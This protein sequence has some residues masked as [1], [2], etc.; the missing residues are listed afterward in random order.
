[1]LRPL[2]PGDIRRVGATQRVQRWKL[3]N[4]NYLNTERAGEINICTN[5]TA[6]AAM[7]RLKMRERERSLSVWCVCEPPGGVCVVHPGSSSSIFN[8]SPA[9]QHTKAALF[10]KAFQTALV[11]D[12]GPSSSFP[13]KSCLTRC[14]FRGNYWNMLPRRFSLSLSFQKSQMHSR[15][16]G[17]ALFFA[18]G[19]TAFRPA[20]NFAVVLI[21]P[22]LKSSPTFR[23]SKADAPGNRWA[24]LLTFTVWS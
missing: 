17:S 12:K 21:W 6:A 13:N 10:S 24:S 3:F 7:F 2:F 23:P 11:V 8:I 16:V 19:E 15:L 1:V 9:P 5:Y 4:E 22:T 14:S 20:S 18:R